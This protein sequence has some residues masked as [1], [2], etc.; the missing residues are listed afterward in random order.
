MQDSFA[1]HL[2]SLVTDVIALTVFCVQR[3]TCGQ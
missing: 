1:G 2:F 3:P